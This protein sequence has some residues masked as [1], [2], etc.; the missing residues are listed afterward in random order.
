M[1]SNL[2]WIG[3]KSQFQK[4]KKIEKGEKDSNPFFE[5]SNPFQIETPDLDFAKEWH[6][7]PCFGHFMASSISDKNEDKVQNLLMWSVPNH[8]KL[9]YGLN[10]GSIEANRFL[11]KTNLK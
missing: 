1:D 4:V 6:F 5:D 2:I 9:I 11:V 7:C 3:F 8:F 10:I